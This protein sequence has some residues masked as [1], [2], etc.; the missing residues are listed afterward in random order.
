LKGPVA[1]ATDAPQPGRLFVNPVMKMMKLMKIF[2][3]RLKETERGKPK[4][5]EKNLSQRHF[6]YHKSHMN[7]PGIET[8][9]PR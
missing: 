9:P 4:Y 2:I 5:S 3:L 7:R 8:G 1:D 6:V